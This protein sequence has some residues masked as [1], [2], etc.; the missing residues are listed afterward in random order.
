MD[1]GGAGHP[2]V[3]CIGAEQRLERDCE[4][5]LSSEKRKPAEVQVPIYLQRGP[6]REEAG[7][8]QLRGLQAK[9]QGTEFY[10]IL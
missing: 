3:G 9:Q 10:R 8:Q 4:E 1:S 7:V 5:T 6:E 2:H